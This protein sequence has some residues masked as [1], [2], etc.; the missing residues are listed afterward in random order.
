MADW[1]REEKTG[2]K[3]IFSGAAWQKARQRGEL[4]E[5][6]E[7]NNLDGMLRREGGVHIHMCT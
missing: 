6:R 1:D 7:K 2:R 4:R 5:D 3:C